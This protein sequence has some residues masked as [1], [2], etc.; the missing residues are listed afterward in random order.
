MLSALTSP[1]LVSFSPI[2][3]ANKDAISSGSSGLLFAPAFWSLSIMT[4]IVAL[5]Y[6]W[7]KSVEY[8]REEM[9]STLR[10]VIESVLGEVAGLGFVGLLLDAVGYP[11]HGALSSLSEEYLGDEEI[12]LESFEFLHLAFF[13]VG[14]GFFVTAGLFVWS[15]LRECEEV[16]TMEGIGL[17]KDGSCMASLP[18]IA[19]IL[20]QNDFI[21]NAKRNDSSNIFL[22]FDDL[23]SNSKQ[24]GART[25]LAR[26]YF[27]QEGKL[28]SNALIEPLIANEFGKNLLEFVELSPLAW[29]PLIPALAL[30]N[31]IDLSHDV[32]NAASANAADSSGYF[33][34]TQGAFYPSAAIVGISIAWGLW[35]YWHSAIAKNYKIPTLLRSSSSDVG[36]LPPQDALGD[37]ADREGAYSS[38]FSAWRFDKQL[39]SIKY[40]TWLCITS[41][42]FFGTQIVSR[43][44][45]ALIANA[46]IGD[47]ENL[48]PEI[49]SYGS[50][51][52]IS[53]LLLVLSRKSFLNLTLA[54]VLTEIACKDTDST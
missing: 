15:S 28:P 17:D 35:N 11:L 30:A 49:L 29:I 4:T 13:Q 50:F 16:K 5:L 52:I 3:L 27:V 45:T 18:T 32:V 14:V 8:L 7:E 6:T 12:L 42:V 26:E 10:P 22:V 34:G 19:S 2:L 21:H 23:A 20:D 40:Q 33:Y 53:A 24:R 25:L 54:E 37:E 47:P 48:I 36:I 9:P 39:A 46:Q 43:D 31:S 51:V 44:I 1:P 41:L 38:I